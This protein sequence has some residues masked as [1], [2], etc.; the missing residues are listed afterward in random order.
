MG[1]PASDRGSLFATPSRYDGS[2]Y[3]PLESVDHRVNVPVA[4]VGAGRTGPSQ[5][6]ELHET[7]DRHDRVLFKLQEGVE[8]GGTWP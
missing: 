8:H 5:L 1:I 3:A 6:S 2:R 7:I 4:V